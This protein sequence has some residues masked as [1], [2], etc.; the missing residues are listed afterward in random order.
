MT[1]DTWL[2]VIGIGLTILFGVAGAKYIQ[3]KRISQ[4][5]D[6]SGGSNAIQSGRD[7]KIGATGEQTKTKRK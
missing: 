1:V 6:V 7:T 5:Q 2:A 4:N 3:R